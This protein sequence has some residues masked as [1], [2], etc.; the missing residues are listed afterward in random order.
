MLRKHLLFY[1]L[2]CL[3]AFGLSKCSYYDEPSAPAKSSVTVDNNGQ[4]LLGITEFTFTVT[5]VAAQNISLLPEGEGKPGIL[6]DPSSF[7]NGKASVKYTYSDVGVFKVVVRTSSSSADGKTIKTDVSEP[8]TVTVTSH[9]NKIKDFGFTSPN[10][11]STTILDNDDSNSDTINV[12]VPYNPFNGKTNSLAASFT[13]SDFATVKVGSTD[14]TS[15]T[16]LNNFSSVVSYT[17]TAADGTTSRTYLVTVTV[18]PVG[19]GYTIKSA[20]GIVL[21]DGALN[22]KKFNAYVDNVN[23]IIAVVLPY[24]TDD[25]VNSAKINFNYELSDT[26]SRGNFSLKSDESIDLSGTKTKTLTVTAQDGITYDYTIY[27]VVGPAFNITVSNIIPNS[28]GTVADFAIS[29]SVLKGTDLSNL[30]FDFST[31][32]ASVSEVDYNGAPFISNVSAADYTSKSPQ[33]FL[34]KTSAGAGKG[35]ITYW[36]TY[37]VDVLPVR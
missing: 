11:T 25:A 37:S 22:K 5:Q 9:Q 13:T 17:V 31:L 7:T 20:N 36:A 23:R 4:G 27:S 16:T 29:I 32:D 34:L 6:I 1:A 3:V 33:D 8:V 10:S 30:I 28:E 18:M 14:Q 26:T 12:V 21:A 24:G 19:T 35:N 2:A 15:G